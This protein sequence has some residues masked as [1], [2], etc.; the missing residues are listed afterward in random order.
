[1][2][3]YIR[4]DYATIRGALDDIATRTTVLLQ[5]AEGIRTE[6]MKFEGAWEDP[7]SATAYQAV[8]TKWNSGFEE[9]TSLLARVKTAAEN[10]VQ[11][12]QTT[13]AQAA[14]GW[15]V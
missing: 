10:A 3:D 8:Q 7:D 6:Q 13:N 15:Q 11:S 14:Q 4:Y 9:I 1:M 2:S 12:M 5:Q